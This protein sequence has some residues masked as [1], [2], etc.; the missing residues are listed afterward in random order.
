MSKTHPYLPAESLKNL[1]RHKN[2]NQLGFRKL[3]SCDESNPVECQPIQ[4][5]KG[6]TSDNPQNDRSNELNNMKL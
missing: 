4:L 6:N 5:G 2:S 3:R 1:N